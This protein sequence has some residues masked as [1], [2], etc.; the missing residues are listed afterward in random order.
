MICA[1]GCGTGRQ[2]AEALHGYGASGSPCA[3]GSQLRQPVQPAIDCSL[4]LLSNLVSAGQLLLTALVA[5]STFGLFIQISHNNGFLP[6]R[7]PSS[8]PLARN[9]C[10]DSC[11]S[12]LER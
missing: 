3:A 11:Y 2:H 5:S 9:P 4:W 12:L 6:V 8:E 10:H 1:C 7:A